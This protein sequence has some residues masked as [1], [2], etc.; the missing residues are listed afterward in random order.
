M[1]TPAQAAVVQ[2]SSLSGRWH[3]VGILKTPETAQ[4]GVEVLG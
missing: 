2:R 3:H 1:L 4:D